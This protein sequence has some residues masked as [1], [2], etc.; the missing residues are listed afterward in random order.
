MQGPLAVRSRAT[1]VRLIG[2][3]T[4]CRQYCAPDARRNGRLG[5]LAVVF[6]SGCRATAVKPLPT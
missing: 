2:G 3:A 4:G 1:D 5:R 6:A